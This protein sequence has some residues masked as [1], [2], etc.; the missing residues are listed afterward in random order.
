MLALL[1][2]T[3]TCNTIAVVQLELA[4]VQENV[5]NLVM[6]RMRYQFW[7]DAVAGI[8]EVRQS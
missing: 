1:Y 5:S 8:A 2:A 6:G 3:S 4:M 7:R